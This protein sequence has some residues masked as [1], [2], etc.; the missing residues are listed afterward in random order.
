MKKIRLLCTAAVM[1][2]ILSSATF[3]QAAGTTL[4]IDSITSK[5]I[6]SSYQLKSIDISIEKAKNTLKDAT[7]G[8]GKG[9][10][11][12]EVK[13]SIYEYTN[14]KEAAKN[15]IKLNMQTQYSSFINT[16]EALDLETQEFQ[17]TESK[18]KRAQLQLSLGTISRNE[19]KTMEQSYYDGKAQLNKAQRKFDS[20]TKTINQASGL[21]LNDT[22]TG[23][24]K[25]IITDT[26]N[27]KTYNDYLNDALQNRVEILNDN[28]KIK[29]KKL[30]FAGIRGANPYNNSP[31][32]IIGK[33]GVTE[34][35]NKL[36]TDKIDISIEINGLY[37]DLQSKIQKLQPQKENY[38]AEKKKYDQALQKYNLG[39]ISKIDF[40]DQSA[41][42]KAAEN[43]LK[44]AQRDVALAKLKLEYASGLGTNS[45]SSN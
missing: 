19:F 39:M 14:L 18:Y 3:V 23:F 37:N 17:N 13:Y 6:E 12:I 29:L 31:E 22:Y 21:S 7:R 8:A 40:Q 26:T 35:E 45:L 33:Y 2:I 11:D 16:K 1:T 32:Y 10:A 25:D 41:A 24:T 5:A 34:A 30:E 15:S 43:S 28:E 20:T 27:I 38:N 9:N 36:E 44:L 42:F 4:D